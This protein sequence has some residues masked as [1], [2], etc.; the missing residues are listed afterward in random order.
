MNKYAQRFK[1]FEQRFWE[2]VE[3]SDTCWIWTG[4]KVSRR[5]PYG[6]TWMRGKSVVSHRV[7]YELHYGPIPPGLWVLH[8]C[9]NHSCVN[10]AHLFLGTGIDNA[11]D[12]VRK[13][14]FANQKLSGEEIDKILSLRSSGLTLRAIANELGVSF[15]RIGEVLRGESVLSRGRLGK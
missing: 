12:A 15:A 9:D 5:K 11:E 2:K 6:T 14:R 8:L 4:A 10:P 1:S 3:K 7:S 13:G